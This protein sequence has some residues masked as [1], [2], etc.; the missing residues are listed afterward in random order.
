ML[1]GTDEATTCVGL[2]IRNQRTG[3]ISVAH[4]DSTKIVDIGI[5][6]MLSLVT[7]YDSDA[8]LDVH[9]VGGFEDVSPKHFNGSSSSK[10]HGKLD[11]YSLPLCTKIIETLR[12]RPE[13]FHIQTLFV[14]RH[15]TKRDFQGN[16][17]P[18]L[19]GFVVE[20]SSGSLKPASFDRTARCPDEIVRRIR[21]T[22]CYKD[23]TWN[24]RL[25]ETYDTEADCFVISPC[26]WTEGLLYDAQT[27]QNLCDTEILLGC[28]TSPF[29]EGPDFVDNLRR[30]WEYLIKY[31]DWKDSF[32]V[33]QPRIF[34]RTADGGWKRRLES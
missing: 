24:G 22:A 3:M 16:A 8:N 9:M 15:N 11:G 2:V 34:E 6:Q 28:S 17:Y 18:I 20:T 32:P 1:V 7:S 25:L 33:K 26:S 19:T 30:Q 5:T 29:A 31:P 10:S 21:V 13:K 23:S 12:W 27:L 4:M 14:L